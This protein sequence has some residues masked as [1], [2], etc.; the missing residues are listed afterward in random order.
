MNNVSRDAKS[1]NPKKLKKEYKGN[2][3]NQNT[4]RSKEC[5]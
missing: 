2:A 1:E 3:R 5:L 4:N